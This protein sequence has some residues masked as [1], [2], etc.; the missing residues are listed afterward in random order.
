MFCPNCG[1]KLEDGAAFCTNCGA[2]VAQVPPQGFAGANPNSG[3]G[4]YAGMTPN[5]GD[6]KGRKKVRLP[7]PDAGKI[8]SSKALPVIGILAGVAVVAGCIAAFAGKQI[9][10]T[11]RVNT[12]TPD[13]YY[14]QIEGDYAD[15]LLNTAGIVYGDYLLDSLQIYDKSYHLE[16]NSSSSD[17]L[18][19]F[20]NL[21]G[22]KED[23]SWVKDVHAK[24]DIMAKDE[25]I[26]ITAS[27]KINQKDIID[28]RAFIDL[29][30]KTAYA[31]VPVLNEKYIKVDLPGRTYTEDSLEKVYY[32]GV[33]DYDDFPVPTLENI[34]TE[35]EK[36]PSA[37]KL[38]GIAN[39][40]ANLALSKVDGV[41]QS[42]ERLAIGDITQEFVVLEVPISTRLVND[43]IHSISTEM[44]ADTELRDVIATLSENGAYYDRI[45]RSLRDYA[46]WSEE[47]TNRY[48]QD[49]SITYMKV[50]VDNKGK[51]CGRVF[52][53][54]ENTDHQIW[55]ITVQDGKRYGIKLFT[56]SFGG[57]AVPVGEV[58][59]TDRSIT[60]TGIGEKRG[61][62][63]NLDFSANVFGKEW[64]LFSVSDWDSKAWMKGELSGTVNFKPTAE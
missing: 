24:A 14:R 26:T 55:Y 2:Q 8:R 50:Y 62:R 42:K 51:I 43:I 56:A 15:D 21:T 13:E 49:A 18:Q 20:V 6:Q 40:Y 19:D 30:E 52:Y 3:Y 60:V 11:I 53:Q 44:D 32:Y 28:G 5:Q 23:A 22:S 64:Q 1:T 16:V 4:A 27:A 36:I 54:K 41:K 38:K 33:D 45:C 57:R 12:M 10:N 46:Q 63:L 47:Y 25:G 37:A 34:R 31:V 7:R 17:K 59:T 29:Q 35:L 58:D 9:V 48:A 61:D 39:R